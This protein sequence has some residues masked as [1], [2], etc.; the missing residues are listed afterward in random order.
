MIEPAPRAVLSRKTAEIG[1]AALLL[2][3]GAAIIHGALDLE[4]GWGSSGPEAGY[5]P[6]RIGVLIVVV[7]A[8]V[9][10]IEAF[11]R[12]GALLLEAG[13]ATRMARFGVPLVALVALVPWIGIY[14]AALAY[15]GITIGLIARAGW[16]IALAVAILVP[17]ALFVLFETVF[18][19]PLPK[20]PLGPLLGMI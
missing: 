8:V 7:A 9:L 1:F 17:S 3:F 2:C 6:L 13:A 12:G 15:L 20:G 18:R 19:T 5:F 11:R 10:V 4:T 16:R 14:L